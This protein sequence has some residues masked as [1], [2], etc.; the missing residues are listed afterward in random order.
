MARH[1]VRALLFAAGLAI[2]CGASLTAF[3]EG[4]SARAVPESFADIIDPLTPAVVNISTTQ[5]MGGAERGP[6]LPQFPPGSPFEEL[7][8]DFFDRHRSDPHKPRKATSLGSGFIIDPSGYIV[9]NNHVISDADEINVILHDNTALKAKVVGKDAKTDVALLKVDTDRKLPSLSFGD[10]DKLRV[11]D[12][13]LAIGNPFGLGGSV[14]A[15]IVSARARDIQSGP[16]DDFIQTDASINRGNSGGPLFNLAGEVVGVNAAI[17]SPSGGS[18]GIGFAIPSSMAKMVVA[19]LKQ[20]GRTRRGW[21][22]VRI[23]SV[24]D[25]IAESLGV[26]KVQGALVASVSENGPAAK[27]G[28]KAGDVVVGFNGRGVE[29]MRRLP[30]MVAETAIGKTVD[31]SVLRAGKELKLKVTVGELEETEQATS[32]PDAGDKGKGMEKR[33]TPGHQKVAELGVTLSAINPATRDQYDLPDTAKGVVIV[34]VDSGSD[35]AD[36][37]LRPG[38][39]IVEVNQTEVT[40][41]ADIAAQLDLAAKAGRKSVL[42][43]VENE[44]G[45]RFVPLKINGKSEAKPDV[46]PEV[47]PEVKP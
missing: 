23:Q 19:D 2:F 29:E 8:K 13:V 11:G 45:L 15:G 43:L 3:A 1:T 39:V 10:S 5:S 20:Y 32:G 28:I 21:L 16:Y 47:K 27:A 40:T 26:G 34:Q 33:S 30:R 44:G 6:E 38:D 17:Y 36:K 7:F 4:A 22:G 35:A 42:L 41:P 46:K 14:T 25:E 24:T 37:G 12:W 9:T 18:V 31:V